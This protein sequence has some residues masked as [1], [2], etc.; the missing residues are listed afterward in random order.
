MGAFDL[1]GIAHS[2]LSTHQTWLD[3]LGHNIANVNTAR[4]TDEAA[5]QAQYVMAQAQG[6]GGV[7]VSGLA[8][9]DP[10]GRLAYDP[11]HPLADEEGMVRRP[12]MDL[13]DQMTGLIIAQRA[14]QANV[15]VFERARDSYLRGLEIGR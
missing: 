1:L 6:T 12:D 3:A 9:G 2:S 10:E 5:F 8:F 15:T 14:Y 7:Q 13:S 11:T 4:R